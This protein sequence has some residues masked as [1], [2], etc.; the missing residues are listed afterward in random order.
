MK[1]ILIS[2]CCGFI[3]SNLCEFLIKKN[4]KIIGIDNLMTGNLNN[5]SNIINNSNFKFIKHDICNEINIDDDIDYILHF[6]SPASPAD[7]LKFPIKTLQI[8]S[9]GTENML[10]IALQKKAVILV[11]STS[12]IYG[13]PLEHPQKESYYG[14]VNPIGPRGVYDEAK[15]Y[16][17]ALT[18]AYNRKFNLQTKIVRIFNTYGSKMRVKDGRAIPNFINQALN[19]NNF[20]VYGDGNQTRSFTYIDDTVE[21][22]Y[23]LMLSNYSDPFNIGNPVENS[24][25]ELIEL[26]KNIIPCNSKIEYLE[27]PENDPKIRKPDIDKAFKLLKWKPKTK[28]SDGLLK[29]I[30][31]F[32]QKNI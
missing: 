29:T 13:D 25:N 7:Y 32:R 14:N 30:E 9:R 5:I 17:E 1:K 22:I 10:N 27:L 2:G 28:L 21:G 26:I 18:M 11:A 24:I 6:A 19:N 4:Y 8:G 3:G 15:R 12:E 16:L 20:T 23:K 31:Y